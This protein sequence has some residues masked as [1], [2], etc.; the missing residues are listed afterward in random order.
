MLSCV[1]CPKRARYTSAAGADVDHKVS[2]QPPV[3]SSCRWAHDSPVSDPGE[4][5]PALHLPTQTQSV[6]PPGRI[7][8]DSIDEEF[9][10][11][12]KVGEGTYG[13][14]YRARRRSTGQIVALKKVKTS[15]ATADDSEVEI[16]SSL[17]PHPSI[18]RLEQ[19]AV[20]SRGPVFTV[21][22]YVEHEVRALLAGTMK[23]PFSPSEAKCLMLQLLLGL[24]HLHQNRVLHRDLKTS[25]LLYNNRG[26]LKICDFGLACRAHG[27]SGDSVPH[28][29]QVV[30]LWYRAPELLLGA[31]SYSTAID[32]WSA[33]C[34]M[35]E[36]LLG[37]PLF[38]G[39]TEIDQLAKI[40]GVL[41]TPDDRIWPGFSE[42]PGI[43]PNKVRFLIGQRQNKSLKQLFPKMS[44]IGSPTLSDTGLDLLNGLLTYHP[45]RRMKAGEALAHRWFREV[46][47]PKDKDFMPTFPPKHCDRHF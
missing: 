28:T 12:N 23:Q 22:E 21:M 29:Q 9:T 2:S 41:G 6:D 32:M 42:L 7:T 17:N 16:L 38:D 31:R 3:L 40:Y 10:I 37:K 47:L 39:N 11:L 26:E 33:G 30:T 34:I 24:N 5:T 13:I 15:T 18:T 4:T 45:K 8:V 43:G 1:P 27:P 25:N 44:F 19:V 35:A 14:V 36:L 46:P 20:S